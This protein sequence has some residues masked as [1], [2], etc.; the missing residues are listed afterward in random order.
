MHKHSELQLMSS[1]AYKSCLAISSQP[2]QGSSL[3]IDTCTHKQDSIDTCTHKQACSLSINTCTQST[4]GVLI[5]ILIN[6]RLFVLYRSGSNTDPDQKKNL[7]T[8]TSFLSS[9]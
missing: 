9:A 1:H 4:T 8:L 5:I 7:M 2:I 3:S 6:N